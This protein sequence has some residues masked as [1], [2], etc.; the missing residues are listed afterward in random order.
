MQEKIGTCPIAVAGAPVLREIAEGLEGR[1]GPSQLIPGDPD[2]PVLSL[3]RFRFEQIPEGTLDSQ[4]FRGMTVV[5]G[6]EY[7][8]LCGCVHMGGESFVEKYAQRVIDRLASLGKDIVY[9]HNEGFALVH[10]KARE[11]G[12][13]TP[14]KYMHLFEYLRNYL[15]DH[16]SSITRLGKKVA[17]QANCAT[18]WV[19][20][21]DAFL[22]EVFELIEVERPPRQYEHLNAVCCTGPIMGTNRELAIDIQQKNVSDAMECGAKALITSCPVCDRVLRR[23]ASQSGLPKIYITDLCRMALGE[24]SW[25][26]R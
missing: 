25:P 7:A 12:I 17:Y 21:Q 23:P 6:S 22:D 19:P 5:R 2:K 15:R 18:R 1:G 16:Q 11:Q 13:V 10:V 9:F 4:L 14:F 20:E 24:K 8:S 26:D 3:D